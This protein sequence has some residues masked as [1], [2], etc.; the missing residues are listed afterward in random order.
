[1]PPST[2]RPMNPK[3]L[4]LVLCPLLAFLSPVSGRSPGALPRVVPP[5]APEQPRPIQHEAVEGLPHNVTLSLEGPL[6]GSIPTDF[7]VTTGG[8]NVTTDLPLEPTGAEPLIG[9]FQATLIPGEPW[10][11]KVNLGARVPIP[12]G[13]GNIEY[14]DYRL[15]TT[16]RIELGQKVILWQKGGQKLT[17]TMAKAEE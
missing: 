1:M 14:R 3:I 9:T 13:N 4:P 7:S 5:L 17:L 12:V 6:F 8:T 15:S 11:A 2:S 10:L 16:V